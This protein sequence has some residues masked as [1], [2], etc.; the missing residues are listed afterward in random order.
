VHI[1]TLHE[2]KLVDGHVSQS[3]LRALVKLARLRE[4]KSKENTKATEEKFSKR[5]HWEA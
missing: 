3:N 1:Q 4:L 5:N 2:I